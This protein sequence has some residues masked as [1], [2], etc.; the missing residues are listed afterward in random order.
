VDTQK[1]GI[2]PAFAGEP[3][4]FDRCEI[5]WDVFVE[6]EGIIGAQE[7][8]LHD[9]MHLDASVMIPAT[10]LTTEGGK[11]K[12]KSIAYYAI[13]IQKVKLLHLLSN[14]ETTT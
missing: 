3:E 14:A 5:Q 10:V 2:V 4:S 6:V 1:K 8:A 7:Y 11:T 13:A 9:Y 12:S